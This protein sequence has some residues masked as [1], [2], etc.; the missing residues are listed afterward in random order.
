MKW[1]TSPRTGKAI[2]IPNKHLKEWRSDM[3]WFANQIMAGKRFVGGVG[4]TLIFTF[5]RPKKHYRTGKYSHLLRDDAPERH[6][7]TPD[8]DKLIRAVLDAL[9]AI[10]FKDDAEVDRVG[11]VKRW[12][13]PEG[14]ECTMRGV[15]Y[16]MQKEEAE[17]KGRR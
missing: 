17:E 1:I 2:P 14:L 4:V 7:Q 15:C 12:G 3:A 10:A 11:A 8:V 9:T 13:S 16:A 6:T 5:E